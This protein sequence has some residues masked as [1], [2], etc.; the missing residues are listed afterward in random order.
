[1]RPSIAAFLVVALYVL[2]QDFWFWRMARPLVFGF[3]P[4]G[5]FYHAAF[6]VASAGLLW[7]LVAHSWPDH[8]EST[9][10]LKVGPTET[11]DPTASAKATAVRRGFERRR[12]VGSTEAP[13]LKFGPEPLA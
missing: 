10:D 3:L 9:P 6:T 11:A 13:D 8:L 4:I 1:V 12:K 2:H 7:L 5:L